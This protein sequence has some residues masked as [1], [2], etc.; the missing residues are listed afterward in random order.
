LGE[1]S[2]GCDVLF[3]EAPPFEGNFP[4]VLGDLVSVRNEV[5]DNFIDLE[6]IVLEKRGTFA[7]E[8]AACS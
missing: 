7:A 6:V 3:G 8:L 4:N 1:E 2:Q 5:L